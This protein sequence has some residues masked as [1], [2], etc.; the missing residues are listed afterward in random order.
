MGTQVYVSLIPDCD[1][2]SSLEGLDRRR[3][4]SEQQR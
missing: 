1:I 4:G 3:R 2:C